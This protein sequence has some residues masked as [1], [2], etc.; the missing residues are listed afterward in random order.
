MLHATPLLGWYPA[1][2]HDFVWNA[3]GVASGVY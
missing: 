2:S 3:E 1:G